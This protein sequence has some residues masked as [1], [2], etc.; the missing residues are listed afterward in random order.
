MISE[1]TLLVLQ[2]A[3]EVA[4]GVAGAIDSAPIASTA[5]M[6]MQ[7]LLVRLVLSWMLL[8]TLLIPRGMARC[9]LFPRQPIWQTMN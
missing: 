2:Q 4:S 1:I 8:L 7:W 6:A 9:E 3:V 5:G